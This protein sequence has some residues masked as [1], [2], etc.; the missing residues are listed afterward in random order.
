MNV[1]RDRLQVPAAA[2][3]VAVWCERRKTMAAEVCT[4]LSP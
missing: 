4:P 2:V 3:D 1:L